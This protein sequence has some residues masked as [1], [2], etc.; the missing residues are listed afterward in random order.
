MGAAQNTPT[1][2][3]LMGRHYGRFAPYPKGTCPKLIT[4]YPKRFLMALDQHENIY[5]EMQ[6][7]SPYSIN[8]I[9]VS[10]IQNIY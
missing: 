4:L 9:E 2:C 3:L 1:I 8:E 5:Q 10:E 7:S 6:F